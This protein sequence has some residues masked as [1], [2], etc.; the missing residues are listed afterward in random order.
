MSVDKN[1]IVP[2]GHPTASAASTIDQASQTE[3]ALI[4]AETDSL[5]EIQRAEREVLLN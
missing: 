5:R 1:V 3:P 2:D 4:A